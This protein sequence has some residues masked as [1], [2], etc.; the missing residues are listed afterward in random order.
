MDRKQFQ[1]VHEGEYFAVKL[2]LYA[3]FEQVFTTA[4]EG[5]VPID[6]TKTLIAFLDFCYVAHQDTLTEDSLRTLDNALNKFHHHRKIFRES[7]VRLTGFSL[8]R[9]HSL[10]H[11]HHHIKKF[12][13][14]NGISSSIT[15]SKHITAV[16]KPWRQSSRYDAL[17]EMLAINTRNDKLTAAWTDFASRG[18]LDG[19]C[20]SEAIE[21]LRETLSDIDESDSDTEEVL[22]SSSEDGQ[23]LDANEDEDVTGPVEGPSTLSDVTLAQKRGRYPSILH[24]K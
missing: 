16:K 4:L 14:P 17:G 6:I 3:E 12:G 5:F 7:G 19:T 2:I 18:M 24:I 10:A 1:G 23:D 8:P 20:L 22:D 13:A 9:Q 21:R 15:E 11:Y